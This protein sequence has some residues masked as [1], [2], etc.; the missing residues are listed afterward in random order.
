MRMKRQPALIILVFTLFFT[1]PLYA[2]KIS[3]KLSFNLNSYSEGDLE[4]WI[5]SRN[6]LWTDYATE[7][8][9]TSA[10][11]FMAPG[12][13]SN[14]EIELRIPVYKGF[15]LN[16][17]GSRLSGEEEREVTYTRAGGSQTEAQYLLNEVSGLNLK[18]GLSYAAELPFLSG[19]HLFGNVGRQ[20]MY[21]KYNVI[22]NYTLTTEAFGREFTY[23]INQENSYKSDSLGWYAGLGV[24]YDVISYVTVV[25][26]VEKIWSKAD[27]F[28]GS[29][30]KK[31]LQD[32][33][34]LPDESE[35]GNASLYYYEDRLLNLDTYYAILK[36]H[37]DKPEDD[38][39]NLRSGL[40][41]FSALSFKFGVRFKF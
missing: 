25:L 2:E 24:E 34:P 23:E 21:A 37:I 9:G 22:D 36:G 31:T 32:G 16:L 18:I 28:K 15:G 26:E 4:T 7:Y 29:H 39:R 12:Y 5:A 11:E 14:I 3:L 1:H 10:G 40:L 6:T 35:S 19:L 27:G 30:D 13:G 38:F 41:N 17:S 8:P 33:V 20:L